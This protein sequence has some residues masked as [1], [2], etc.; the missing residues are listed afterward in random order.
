MCRL[1]RSG[2]LT[3]ITAVD[4]RYY[5]LFEFDLKF[6]R[7]RVKIEDF[8]SRVR[9]EEVTINHMGE[10]VLVERD[11][12]ISLYGSSPMESAVDRLWHI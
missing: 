12:D 11:L 8:G 5:Q 9:Y 1:E 2:A 6:E 4:E 3:Y 10:R 7:G